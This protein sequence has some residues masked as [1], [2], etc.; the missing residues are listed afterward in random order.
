M[1]VLKYYEKALYFYESSGVAACKLNNYNK[2]LDYFL[3]AR[4]L[5]AKVGDSAEIKKSK[6]TFTK[7]LAGFILF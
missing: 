1:K 5:L 4:E 3:K 2:A 7:R 6:I